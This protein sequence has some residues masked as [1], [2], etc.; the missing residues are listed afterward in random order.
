MGDIVEKRQKQ[1]EIL[2]RIRKRAEPGKTTSESLEL[3]F[4]CSA[5]KREFIVLLERKHPDRVYRVVRIATEDTVPH[6][7]SGL[8]RAAKELDINVDEI[9]YGSIKCPYCEG[10]NWSFIK[11][12]CGKLS[13]AG[14]V[15]ECGDKY[16]H[17]C[18]WCGTAGFIKGDIEKVSG[19]MQ[20]REQIPPSTK[21][22]NLSPPTRGMLGEGGKQNGA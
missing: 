9:E 13:C 12:G 5:T 21:S 18:P 4:R 15:K 10:G 6:P 2:D 16:R 8:S 20:N 22:K 3:D 14:G 11:C 7:S 1:K 17:V 19:K